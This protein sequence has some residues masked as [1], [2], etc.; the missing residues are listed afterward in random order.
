MF[1]LREMQALAIPRWL[2]F[3]TSRIQHADRPPAIHRLKIALSAQRQNFHYF[4]PYRTVY[5]TQLPCPQLQDRICTRMACQ[6]G[7]PSNATSD[8][9]PMEVAILP[10]CLILSRAGAPSL[11][12][13][14]MSFRRLLVGHPLQGWKKRCC[15][16]KSLTARQTRLSGFRW[17]QARSQG[18]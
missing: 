18:E 8:R 13:T 11:L 6:I 10:H 1:L 3:S 9:R 7:R 16:K 15:L 4:H 17:T 14:A 12:R 2:L 5:T